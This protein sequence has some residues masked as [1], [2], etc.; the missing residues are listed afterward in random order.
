MIA[1]S[2]VAW[3]AGTSNRVVVYNGPPSWKSIPGLLKKVYK[4]GLQMC[5]DLRF[6]SLAPTTG[7]EYNKGRKF[8]QCQQTGSFKED[9]EIWTLDFP[10]DV[11]ISHQARRRSGSILWPQASLYSHKET[12]FD[13][14]VYTVHKKERKKERSFIFSTQRK[15]IQ[16]SIGRIIGTIEQFLSIHNNHFEVT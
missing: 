15:K 16:I 12:N 10:L 13:C 14:K 8:Y 5:F 3:R 11:I 6:M 1:Q 2:C 4:F 7:E 9:K